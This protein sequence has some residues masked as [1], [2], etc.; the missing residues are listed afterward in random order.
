MSKYIMIIIFDHI[1]SIY[2]FLSPGKALKEAQL[3]FIT[4][5]P[6]LHSLNIITK[7]QL[8]LATK[9]ERKEGTK[10]ERNLSMNRIRTHMYMYMRICFHTYLHEPAIYS[11]IMG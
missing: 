4:L 2:L 7:M 6:F 5:V 9:R 8:L 10:E 1:S 11:I 3:D